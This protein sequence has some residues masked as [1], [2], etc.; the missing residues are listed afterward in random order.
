MTILGGL[1]RKIGWA[2]R[3]SIRTTIG[4]VDTSTSSF[5]SGWCCHPDRTPAHVNIQI[6]GGRAL[7]VAPNARRDDLVAHGVDPESGFA[8]I[9]PEPLLATD[10][11]RVHA[12]DGYELVNSTRNF[13]RERLNRLMVG[14]DPRSMVGLEIGALDRPIVSKRHGDVRYVDHAASDELRT[15]YGGTPAPLLYPERIVD[16]DYVWSGGDLADKIEPDMK[17]DYC[18][19]VHVM[20]HV[21]NPIGWLQ[22]IA[23]V[24]KPGGIIALV[25]PSQARSFDYRRSFTTPSEMIEAYLLDVQRPTIRQVFDHVAFS[26]PF[27]LKDDAIAHYDRAKLDSAIAAALKSQADGE[28]FDA[29]CNVFDLDNFLKCWDVVETLDLLPL[30]IKSSFAPYLPHHDEFIVTFTRN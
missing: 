1:A 5:I 2:R 8:L 12:D 17:F 13:H 30:K 4:M 22:K 25:L 20:E 11:V 24:L 18:L 3:P 29:H 16:V 15:K 6:N 23:A 27:H 26:S 7:R 10:E 9:L 28:Y 14:I 21:A 19:A